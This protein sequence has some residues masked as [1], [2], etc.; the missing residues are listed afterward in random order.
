MVKNAAP[1]SGLLWIERIQIFKKAVYICFGTGFV[2][3]V[4]IQHLLHKIPA[5]VIRCCTDGQRQGQNQHN[6]TEKR[7]N[8]AKQAQ[9]HHILRNMCSNYSTRKTPA[10]NV[11]DF[12]N[13]S[14]VFS[15]EKRYNKINILWS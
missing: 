3:T 4:V 11:I 14:L 9:I 5:F 15:F 13:G 2:V 7:K 8:T 12:G 6:Y 1:E 10:S